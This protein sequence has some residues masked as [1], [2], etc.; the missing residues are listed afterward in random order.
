M[1]RKITKTHHPHIHLSEYTK[2]IE[3]EYIDG[4]EIVP[5]TRVF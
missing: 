5:S 4:I 3:K 1:E 2:S